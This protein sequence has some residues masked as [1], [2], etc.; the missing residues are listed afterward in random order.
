M[1]IIKDLI[2]TG[3]EHQETNFSEYRLLN[4]DNT[5]I[6]WGKGGYL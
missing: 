6:W 2:L 3:I 1:K 5:S 4:I